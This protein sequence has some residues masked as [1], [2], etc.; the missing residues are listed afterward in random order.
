MAAVDRVRPLGLSYGEGLERL[1]AET[2]HVQQVVDIG[3]PIEG[4]KIY[5]AGSRRLQG[6]T[7]LPLLC[8]GDAAMC[9]DPVS[10]QGI[11]KALRSGIFAAYTIGDF[12]QNGDV[13]GLS[14]YRL[15]LDRE[16]ISYRE[17]LRGYYTQES[18]WPN[19]PFWRRRTASAET[20]CDKTLAQQGLSE[21]SGT[22]KQL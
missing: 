3:R 4:P 2:R 17:A 10:G 19:R 20:W 22:A 11:I 12:L 13:R 6:E 18:R 7:T 1:L 15:M 16:F 14:R 21:R 5:P 8:A 9:Y